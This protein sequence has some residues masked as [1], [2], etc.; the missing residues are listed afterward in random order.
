MKSTLQ[1]LTGGMFSDNTTED[2]VYR[3]N[4]KRYMWLQGSAEI[5][6]V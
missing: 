6:K 1:K 4:E 2:S 5:A 3:M